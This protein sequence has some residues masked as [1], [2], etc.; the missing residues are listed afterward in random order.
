MRKAIFSFLMATLMLVAGSAVLAQEESVEPLPTPTTESDEPVITPLPTAT[1]PEENS[2]VEEVN[3]DETVT[4]ADLR[5]SEPK[6]LPDSKFYFLKN[7]SRSIKSALTFNPVKKAE[8]KMQFASEK[9][10]EAQK[11]A[12]KVKKPEIIGRAVESYQ[13][14][15]EAIKKAT[16]KIK[17]K[18]V[19]NI[20]V[21]E[22]LDKFVKQQVLHQKILDK[23][24]EKVPE[25]VA[26][27]IEAVR[28][29]YLEGF[30]EV[31]QKLE[32]KEQIKARLENNLGDIEGSEFKDFK[33]ME[34]LKRIEEK[35]PEEIKEKIMEVRE[36]VLTEFKQKIEDLPPEKQERLE[37]YIEKVKGLA[38]SKMEILEDVKTKLKENPEMKEKL[39]TTRARIIK[40]VQEKIEE[41]KQV[42]CP[43]NMI[44]P[45]ACKGRVVIKRDEN[46]CPVPT[47]IE[48]GDAT[49]PSQTTP[50][51]SGT[52]PTI[53]SQEG[54]DCISLW[55]PVCGVNGKTYSNACWAKVANAEIKHKG[56][57]ETIPPR[58]TPVPS[59]PP[60]SILKPIAPTP[61]IVEPAPQVSPAPMEQD[62]TA[63]GTGGNTE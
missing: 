59:T 14:E 45:A 43:E 27:K 47:C 49:S 28:E 31:M 23:L 58:S 22:F 10:L 40:E 62:T 48:V 37:Q 57:C 4:A 53:P 61:T 41:N 24:E 19:Q 20:K 18:A 55:D 38:E 15:I 8:L 26:E 21:G 6:L 56:P 29:R 2:A 9:L 30:G 39:E 16:D 44:N 32:D 11:L 42:K 12:E 50:G 25:Q 33:N 3:I 5:I 52:A 54:V 60:S 34:I 46:G 1:E 7:W 17:E 51:D 13:N 63:G 36:E 35:A